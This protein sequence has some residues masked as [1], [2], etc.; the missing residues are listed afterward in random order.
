[1][2]AAATCLQATSQNLKQATW[3]NAKPSMRAAPGHA[4]QTI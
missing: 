2:R 1:M 4:N 3:L